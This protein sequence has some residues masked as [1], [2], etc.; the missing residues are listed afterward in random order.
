MKN[1]EKR[2][3]QLHFKWQLVQAFD[4]QNRL[5]IAGSTWPIRFIDQKLKNSI[6]PNLKKSFAQVVEIWVINRGKQ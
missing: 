2:M 6:S 5:K 3:K 4:Q 1:L